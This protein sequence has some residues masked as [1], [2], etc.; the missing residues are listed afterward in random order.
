ME[1][2]ATVDIQEEEELVVA[3]QVAV[4]VLLVDMETLLVAQI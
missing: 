1:P 2:V 3:I 4:V